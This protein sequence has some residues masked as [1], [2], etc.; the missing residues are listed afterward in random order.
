[1]THTIERIER[2]NNSRNGNP[3]WRLHLTSPILAGA[4]REHTH[5]VTTAPD[6]NESYALGAFVEGKRITDLV[7]DGR[8]RLTDWRIL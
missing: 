2:L 6:L 4:D 7:F 3:T 8:G 1:M 5:P